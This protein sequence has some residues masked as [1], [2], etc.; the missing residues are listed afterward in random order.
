MKSI[1]NIAEQ[2]F[3][4]LGNSFSK[5][6]FDLFLN[7]I[8]HLYTKNQKREIQIIY[9]GE[10]KS[11]LFNIYNASDFTSFSHSFFRI[12]AKGKG[13]I[14]KVYSKTEHLKKWD[15]ARVSEDGFIR[16]FEIIN[17]IIHSINGVV[18][19]NDF[20]N[21]NGSV[22]EYFKDISNIGHFIHN[23]KQNTHANRIR[24]RDYY[25][26][27]IHQFKDVIYYP[28]SI[29]LSATTSF[30][31]AQEFSKKGENSLVIVG[32]IPKSLN[33]NQ[34]RINFKYLNSMN[35]LLYNNNLPI[36]KKR[37]YP[38]QKEITLKGGL[39]PHYIVGYFCK[40]R[41]NEDVFE[42]NPALLN[43]N[44]EDTSWIQTG[45]TINQDGIWEEI[46]ETNISGVFYVGMD[47]NFF[48]I[49]E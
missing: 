43:V 26:T 14:E 36:V 41:N 2:N 39:L 30:V 20:Y 42:I 45:L 40:N 29:M 48:D 11:K 33:K 27:Q 7:N 47:G 19:Y 31:K 44:I 49:N 18:K 10:N 24:I 21:S 6:D 17:L 12:G 9:R 4:L 38:D 23:I 3:H 8:N 25:L 13:Y 16:I 46:K 34:Y 35:E 28:V 37:F 32:W 15:I 5:S 1:N 22:V